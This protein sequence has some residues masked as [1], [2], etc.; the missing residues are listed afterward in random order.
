MQIKIS[1]ANALGLQC[2]GW[3]N[4]RNESIINF[5]ITTPTPIFFKTFTTDTN[6]HTAEYMAEKIEEVLTEIGPEK[7]SALVTDNASAMVK[8]RNNIHEKY[9]HISVYGCVAHTLNLLIGDISKM[10]TM[11]SIEDD[12]K[13]I[14][15]EINNSHLLLATF[16]KIQTEKKGTSVPISLKLSVKTRWGSIT[17]SLKS[18][19]DTK[20]AL[21]ALAVCETVDT[22]LSKQVERLVLDEAVFWVRVLKLFNLINPIVEYITKLES[23]KPKLSQVVECFYSLEKHFQTVLPSSPLTKQE[24]QNLQEFLVK[25]KRIV[26]N[27]VH[28]AANILDPRFNGVHLTNE[29]FIME[30]GKLKMKNN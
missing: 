21:K 19:L 5:I 9:K 13:S 8:A 11:A 30:V 2:D 12:V 24:E 6:R 22:I 18:L 10:R 23:D 7:F 26:I 25:R 15:K 28:L 3:S 29:R 27:P 20:Y 14:V 1:E 4:R 16:K 17:H